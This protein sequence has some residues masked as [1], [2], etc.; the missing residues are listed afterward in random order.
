MRCISFGDLLQAMWDRYRKIA[1]DNFGKKRKPT[2]FIYVPRSEF[3]EAECH[4]L[5]RSFLQ[6]AVIKY[7]PRIVKYID[8]QEF[9]RQF[10]PRKVKDTNI[11]K[12][13][14]TSYVINVMKV[15]LL[16]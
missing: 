10:P 7:V 8:K 14:V 9:Y 2:G 3:R 6:N 4:F 11:S 12:I 15:T 1:R 5:M 13:E 16:S